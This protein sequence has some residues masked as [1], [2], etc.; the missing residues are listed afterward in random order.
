MRPALARAAVVIDST[1]VDNI[2]PALMTTDEDWLIV[3]KDGEQ[4]GF[5]Y[6]VYGNGG[7]GAISD[8][9]ANLEPHLARGLA[10]SDK[11]AMQ[12]EESNTQPD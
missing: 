1:S 10:M 2:M 5:V 6:L 8:Y 11:L 3:K 7:W 12:S 4:D 9:S